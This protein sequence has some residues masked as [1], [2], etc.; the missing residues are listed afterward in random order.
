MPQDILET[1]AA[2]RRID[3]EE[4]K[5]AMTVEELQ[6]K[7]RRDFPS[8][9]RDLAKLIAKASED[10][11][12][13][14]AAEFKRASPSKGLMAPSEDFLIEPS[15]SAYVKAGAHLL[16][17]L[18]EP[19]WFK[20]SL[21]DMQEARRVVE[22]LSTTPDESPAILRKD[23]VIDAYQIDEARAY[24]A[25]TLLLIVSLLPTVDA[26][27]PLIDKSRE[28]GMEP[29]VEVNSTEELTVALEAGSKV[30]GVNNR[31]LRTFVVDMGTTARV[32]AAVAAEQRA[33]IAVLS[34]SGLRSA[35]D[36]APLVAECVA[37]A[38]KPSGADDDKAA[39]K[40]E[41]AARQALRGFLI[42][43]AL[44][45]ASDPQ[46]LV[47]EFVNAARGADDYDEGSGS[48]SASSSS[49]SSSLPMA[50]KVCGVKRTEDA[51]LAA[52]SGADLVGMIM[53]KASPRFVGSGA[54]CR[55]ICGA[56]KAFREQDPL[57]LLNTLLANAAAQ[58][59]SPVAAP[60]S[61]VFPALCKRW[62]LFRRA[63]RKARPLTVGVFVN[64]SISDLIAGKDDDESGISGASELDAWQLHGKEGVDEWRTAIASGSV[65]KPVIKVLHV[66][67]PTDERDIDEAANLMIAWC[68]AGATGLLLD[69]TVK[70]SGASGGTGASFDHKAVLAG[71][72]ARL[73]AALQ[74]EAD[75]GAS[76]AGAVGV[77]ATAGASFSLPVVLAGGL[78]PGSVASVIA[79]VSLPTEAGNSHSCATVTLRLA[80]VDVSS[81]VEAEGGPKGVKEEAKVVAFIK[82]AKEAAAMR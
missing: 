71:I 82:N 1:I 60:L 23:F 32:V 47:T 55:A 43:E 49:S 81:G 24:G 37:E 17:V 29:L 53:V 28:L 25:D 39:A 33:D 62:D 73:N 68:R 67:V 5:K 8:P 54:G 16:S 52:R 13:I 3:V 75:A 63:A 12:R 46:K 31:N 6:A 50:V 74:K 69:T 2:Q 14:I 76:A 79:S 59:S 10:D 65:T 22:G 27:K 7:A 51:L 26:L 64:P 38:R 36:I 45:R 57:P 42:G 9:R 58:A 72:E 61:S 40:K 4:S 78:T 80:A 70:A 20:G 34:L 35:E 44:M 15:V 56:L 41:G 30:I 48:A 21:E 18:T 11:Q 77:N 19:K 66:A